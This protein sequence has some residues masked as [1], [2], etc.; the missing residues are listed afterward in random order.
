MPFAARS[1]VWG[2]GRLIVGNVG[3]NIAGASI[4]LCFFE[5]CV[6]SGI[7]LWEGLMARPEWSVG[8]D[9]E[10]STMRR[11]WPTT[12]CQTIAKKKGGGIM[13]ESIT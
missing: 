5:F 12:G 11:P 1:K 3:V 13:M 2:C 7:G 9:R 4:S 6:L 10:A 8:C